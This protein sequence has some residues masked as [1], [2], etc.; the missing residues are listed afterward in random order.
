M[1]RLSWLRHSGQIAR[2]S[3]F[4]AA[5]FLVIGIQL[6]FWP[7]WLSGHGLDA[8]EI[9]AV[10]AAAI[11]AKV[12]ATPAIG[13]LA[14][15]IGRRRTVMAGLAGIA[16]IFYLALWPVTGFWPLLGLN[17]AAGVAQSALLPLGDAVTLAAVRE[18][19]L[20][21]GRIRVWGSLS[22]VFASVGGGAA[23]AVMPAPVEGPDNRI[24]VLVLAASL[25][26][27]AACLAIPSASAG[28]RH[29]G[30]ALRAAASRRGAIGPL[31]STPRFWL[32]VV[33]ASALQASHQLYYGFGTLYWRE[34]GFPDTVI[35]LLWAEGV[36]AEIVLFWY[37]AP[38]IARLGPLGLLAL[39][40]IGGIVR[41]S[42][43]GLVPGLGAAALLQLLHALTFGA[44]HLGAMY[45]L[46]RTVPPDAAASA[47]SLYAALSAGLGSGL[48]MLAAGSLYAAYGG[49][50]YLFMA[51]LSALGLAGVWRLRHV[52]ARSGEGQL[53]DAAARPRTE[54]EARPEAR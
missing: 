52:S 25:L 20:D 7:V 18:R 9:A 22:F 5:L 50:A 16:C 54:R 46:A 42:L 41:W 39:G 48:V 23:L 30:G 36:V 21:Y 3:V 51:L 26:L 11:W 44:S 8:E 34:L 32:L 45:M 19:G 53:D 17:L 1:T 43:M 31:L 37:G 29:A 14:D 28:R 15:R 40:G 38:I 47:Q 49:Q 27:V 13:A 4:N 6:P 33:S 10:F 24:L 12:V 2:L 35:G